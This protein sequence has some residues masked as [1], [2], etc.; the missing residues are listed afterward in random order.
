MRWTANFRALAASAGAHA[1]N[2]GP[3]VPTRVVSGK[4]ASAT[5]ALADA[6]DV[7]VLK[8]S[9]AGRAAH[10]LHFVLVPACSFYI[11]QVTGTLFIVY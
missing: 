7:H 11:T 5:R 8:Q 6:K 3:S 1:R 9:S 10:H 4:G 2:T